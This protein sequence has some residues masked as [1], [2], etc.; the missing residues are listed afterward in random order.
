MTEFRSRRGRQGRAVHYPIGNEQL[1]PEKIAELSQTAETV[2][3]GGCGRVIGDNEAAF[4]TRGSGSIYC[5]ECR[6]AIR[7][8][9]K[10]DLCS[11]CGE[12]LE[13]C[14]CARIEE[15]RAGP[16]NQRK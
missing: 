10:P 3:C 12:A 6:T 13:E 7:T 2:E 1:T 16:S 14:V 11:N 5:T 9:I 8:G 15:E 4:K